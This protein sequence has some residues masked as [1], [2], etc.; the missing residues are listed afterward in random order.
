[1]RGDRVVVAGDDERRVPDGPQPRQAR[2]GEQRSHPVHGLPGI[3][4]AP[5]M[6][7]TDQLRLGAHA[8]AEHAACHLFQPYRVVAPRVDKM[9]ERPQVSGLREATERRRDEDQAADAAWVRDSHLLRQRAAERH[10]EH[11]SA[12]HAEFVEHR[13]AELGQRP[14]GHRQGGHL[15]STDTR[16][17]ECDR[18]EPG[19]VR[20]QVV[21]EPDLSPDAG[22]KQ[23]RLALP[24]QLDVNFDSLDAELPVRDLRGLLCELRGGDSG[25]HGTP[26]GAWRCAIRQV[27]KSHALPG[28]L[29]GATSGSAFQR[30]TNE[31]SVVLWHDQNVT[32]VTISIDNQ[33]NDQRK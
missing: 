16:W 7:R 15:R 20:Q 2:P 31:R 19:Q 21:P 12:G 11:V 23:Q 26:H 24:A 29:S 22:V 9:P 10:A 32:Q 17:V 1:M 33:P 5:D 3:L 28:H 27:S 25:C 8:S 6:H 4:R 30:N 18:A 13:S 14:H